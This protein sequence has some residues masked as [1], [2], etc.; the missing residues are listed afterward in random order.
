M[1]KIHVLIEITDGKIKFDF[2]GSDKQV[3]GPVNCLWPSVAA[4]VQYVVKCI[5]DPDLPANA[6]TFRPIDIIVPEGSFLN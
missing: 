5:I 2:S 4:C 1:I 3:K 6:G